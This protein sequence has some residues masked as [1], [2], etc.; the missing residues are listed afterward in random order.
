MLFNSAFVNC[1][2]CNIDMSG[3]SLVGHMLLGICAPAHHKV[4]VNSA[5]CLLLFI[6]NVPAHVIRSAA[7]TK[8]SAMCRCG[9][10]TTD[11]SC[12]RFTLSSGGR[13]VGSI[14]LSSHPMG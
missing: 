11:G 14:V 8:A 2:R 5:G 7:G 3:G 1:G 13:C 4:T 12:L 6:C 10:P 9:G